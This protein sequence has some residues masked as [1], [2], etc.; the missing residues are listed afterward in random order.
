MIHKIGKE[1]KAGAM[2][3]PTKNDQDKNG[4]VWWWDSWENKWEYGEYNH[5]IYMHVDRYTKWSDQEVT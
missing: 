1:V 5:T 2:N 4:C 3:R